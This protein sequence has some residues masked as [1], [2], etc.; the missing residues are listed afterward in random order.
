LIALT[1][2]G[3]AVSGACA[4]ASLRRLRFAAEATALSPRALVSA[5]RKNAALVPLLLDEIAR[6]PG[7]E[8]EHDLVAALGVAGRSHVALVNEQLAELDHRVERWSRVPRVCASISTSTAFLLAA[9]ALLVATGAASEEIDVSGAIVSVA[10]V[11]TV[12]IA[13][14][15]LCASAQ[16][17][18]R[19]LVDDRMAAVDALVE[20]FEG[21]GTKKA[22]EP[23]PGGVGGVGESA[24]CP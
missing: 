12:G 20:L 14:A 2:A 15:V 16:M 10:N 6:E 13:G 5:G 4:W 24:R 8:W 18:A 11:V 19:A 3:L 1:A 9:M 17:R 7:A 21:S 23:V 22:N